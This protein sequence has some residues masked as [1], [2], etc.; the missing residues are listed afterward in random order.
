MKP[1]NLP[2]GLVG[3][4]ERGSFHGT[5]PAFAWRDWRKRRKT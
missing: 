1:A 3:E 4:N 2:I 5:I